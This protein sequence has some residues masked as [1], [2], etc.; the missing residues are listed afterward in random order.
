MVL[1]LAARSCS[2][3]KV[4]PQVL[5]R[6]PVIGV[7]AALTTPIREGL[8]DRPISPPHCRHR[9]L[10]TRPLFS[11]RGR[12]ATGV[13]RPR[14]KAPRMGRSVTVYRRST[15][16]ACNSSAIHCRA[17][18]QDFRCTHGIQEGRGAGKNAS[19][20]SSRATRASGHSGCSRRIPSIASSRANRLISNAMRRRSSPDIDL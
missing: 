18:L 8:N 14:Q 6:H 12:R 13:A 3:L 17:E 20:S 1:T 5:Q 9:C 7:L 15:L 16:S 10:D 19:R 2:L 11:V 4:D